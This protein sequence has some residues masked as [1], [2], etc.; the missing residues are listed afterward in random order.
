MAIGGG[1]PTVLRVPVP[2]PVQASGGGVLPALRV[3]VTATDGDV[4]AVLE[5]RSWLAMPQK[6]SSLLVTMADGLQP[7]ARTDVYRLA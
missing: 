2:V 4:P 1:V 7:A 6:R 5:S 3:P